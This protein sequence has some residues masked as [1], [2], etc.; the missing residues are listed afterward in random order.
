MNQYLLLI[1]NNQKTEFMA[2]EWDRFFAAAK[3]SGTFAGGSEIGARQV[4]GDTQSAQSTA[5]IGGYM[6]FDSDDKAKLIEL[7]KL[8][9]VVLHG[10]SLELCE[11]PKS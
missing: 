7:L 11:L 2:E 3:S 1:Q 5:H 6:R 9:P 4:L 8:H 10:C